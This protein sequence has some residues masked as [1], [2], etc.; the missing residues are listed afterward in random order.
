MY[1]TRKFSSHLELLTLLRGTPVSEGSTGETTASS[2]TLTDNTGTPFAGVVVGDVV[3]IS[4]ESTTFIVSAVTDDNNI[5]VSPTISNTH[6]S[7]SFVRWRIF[8]N[9][10]INPL[11]IIVGPTQ[12]P[13]A[14]HMGI[15]IYD[16]R[17]F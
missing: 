9:N 8:K 15:I 13:L 11:D 14:P 16:E 5:D 17:D 4:G 1:I 3:H 6:A 2:A 12:D 7:P 10:G